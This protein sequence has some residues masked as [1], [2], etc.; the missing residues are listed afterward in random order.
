MTYTAAFE[1]IKARPDFAEDLGGAAGRLSAD[2]GS[3]A[4]IALEN[5]TVVPAAAKS[6]SPWTG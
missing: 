5:A 2:D 4:Q 6:F 3:G 1:A